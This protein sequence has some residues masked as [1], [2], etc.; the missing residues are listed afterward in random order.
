MLVHLATATRVAK[1]VYSILSSI[2]GL[3]AL[4]GGPRRQF[5]F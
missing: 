2:F 1:L 3:F 4:F 5:A